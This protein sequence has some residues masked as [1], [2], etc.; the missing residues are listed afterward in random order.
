MRTKDLDVSLLVLLDHI[1]FVSCYL[2]LYCLVRYIYLDDSG[3]NQGA[4]DVEI[5]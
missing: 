1:L 5:K 3:S 4:L 2:L